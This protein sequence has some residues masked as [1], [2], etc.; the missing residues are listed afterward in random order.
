MAASLQLAN[1]GLDFTDSISSLAPSLPTTADCPH[2][3]LHPIHTHS[4]S[5]A[6]SS[7]VSKRRGAARRSL[8]ILATIPKDLS[9]LI[10]SHSISRRDQ[11]PL[12]PLQIPA[13]LLFS[14]YADH[15]LS[16]N[17]NTR[18]SLDMFSTTSHTEEE[19]PARKKSRSENRLYNFLTRS[20]SRSRSNADQPPPVD[21]TVPQLPHIP[22]MRHSSIGSLEPKRA[23]SPGAKPSTR[24]QSR[25]L[26][27]TT[28]ATNTTITPGTPKAR[29]R[30]PSAI[31]APV[32]PN[33]APENDQ[34]SSRPTT[35][36]PSAA[37]KKLHNIFGISL[38]KSSRSRSRPNSPRA[39]LDVPPLPTQPYDDDPTPKPRKSF[40]PHASRPQSPSPAANSKITVTTSNAT[41][42]TSSTTST[43]TSNSYRLPKFFSSTT[44]VLSQSSAAD[45]SAARSA[46]P[47]SDTRQPQQIYPTP[48]SSAPAV[49][50]AP[51]KRT[52][53][54]RRNAKLGVDVPIEPSDITSSRP[55]A[56]LPSIT[57]TPLKSLT[58][59]SSIPR[60]THVPKNGSLD[61]GY[62]YRGAT[63]GVVD[64]EGRTVSELARSRSA[65]GK[66]REAEANGRS[67]LTKM[68]STTRST[69]HGSFDFERP[70]WGASIIQR[71][72]SGGTSGTS[73][74]TWSRSGE[75]AVKERESALGPGLAGVG[76][77]QRETSMKRAKER[78]EHVRK[79]ERERKKQIDNEKA[80]IVAASSQ[81]TTPVGSSS[82]HA[83]ASTSTSGTG[84]TG[85]SSS[86]SKA[87]GKRGVFGTK[88]GTRLVG[89]STQ[90]GAFS[91]EPAVPSPTRSTGSTGTAH[92]ASISWGGRGEKEKERLRDERERQSQRK[93]VRRG[94]RAPVPVPIPA[95]N[96][97][98]GHRS[99]TKGR[100][101]DL[102]LGLSWAP[103]KVREDA[104][105]PSTTFFNRSVSNSSGGRSASGSTN[106]R[107]ASTSTNGHG[108]GNG[109]SKK[110]DADAEGERT[111][112]GRELADLFRNALDQKGYAAFKNY[113]HQ[114][115]AH[116]IPFDGPS[117]II[118][119]VGQLLATAPALSEDKK[120]RMLDN[121]VRIILQ[122][123]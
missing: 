4:S 26:S 119:R 33:Q 47:P 9:S 6:A 122:N 22:H 41:Q 52:S 56:I 71:S 59:S 87:T 80:A 107:S 21:D 70:G 90:H 108:N 117:G 65:K 3:P 8:S 72:G 53:S 37:R 118:S 94:D 7:T 115:D 93:G 112:L 10:R 58:D 24:V 44:F 104:L 92:E 68:S 85:K 50:S 101:L 28:T 69:K 83:H 32:S 109:W 110:A 35:P 88:G 40:S 34:P 1:P 2:P 114:F 113:V 45:F 81:R 103:T 55:P 64:E 25:P 121:F 74:S 61:A 84:H 16:Y 116:E 43:A 54:H 97:N 11:S 51:L 15:T 76:T 31:P 62:R 100:S 66:T 12:S 120:R 36:K 79:R 27:S 67:G 17:Q 75:S 42:N 38:R 91:F 111:K 39:S 23:P 13:P 86:L 82:D 5:T 73:G 19:R 60:P 63:M 98:V 29:K 99:G 89:L 20:R 123:A 30:P 102:G 78:D 77:L 48:P 18:P 96:P 49:V 105:M 106:G 14:G 46:P 95:A 57:H